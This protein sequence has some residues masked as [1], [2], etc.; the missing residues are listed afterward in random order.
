MLREIKEIKIKQIDEQ[1]EELERQYNQKATDDIDSKIKSLKFQRDEKISIA[2]TLAELGLNFEEAVQILE[3]NN[4]PLTLDEEDKAITERRGEFQRLE[5]F[6]LV[7]VTRFAPTE[8]KIKSPKEAGAS[9]SGFTIKFGGKEYTYDF[10]Y[11]RDTVH[12]TVNNEVNTDHGYLNCDDCKYAILIPLADIP[13]ERMKGE[14]A[15]MYT[16]NGGANLTCNSY[17]LCPKGKAKELMKNN[18]GVNVIEY[19]GESV[20][21][22]ATAFLSTLGYRQS[23]T[24][25]HSFRDEKDSLDFLKIIEEHKI[26]GETHFYSEERVVEGVFDRFE[27]EIAIYRIISENGLIQNEDDM[28]KIIEEL[29][30]DGIISRRRY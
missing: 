24:N 8:S 12:F 28:L 5:D 13:T 17:I 11:M 16:V 7:H 27:Q 14:A 4:I 21:G 10:P 29:R 26:K 6:M 23:I 20:R 30:E 3:R 15:D 25:A 18:P 9:H 22:Y 1:I 2:K 19:V